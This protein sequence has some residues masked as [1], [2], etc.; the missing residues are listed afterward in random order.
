MID[1]QLPKNIQN[2]NCKISYEYHGFVECITS[3]LDARDPCLKKR[4]IL[5]SSDHLFSCFWGIEK[6][7]CDC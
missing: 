7:V 3:A 4:R 2:D 6:A 1:T 5:G